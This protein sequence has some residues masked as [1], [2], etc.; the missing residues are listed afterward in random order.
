[1]AQISAKLDPLDQANMMSIRNGL[2]EGAGGQ[3]TMNAQQYEHLAYGEAS[4]EHS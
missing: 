4:H 2:K 1:M 3:G